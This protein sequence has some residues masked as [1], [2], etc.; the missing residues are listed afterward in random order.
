MLSCK[1]L[2]LPKTLIFHLGPIVEAAEKTTN[3]PQARARGAIYLSVS[4]NLQGG[5]EVMALNTGLLL[6]TS[7]VTKLP[8]T[9]VVVKTVEN[10]PYSQVLRA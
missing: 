5:H 2:N 8:I 10:L 9:D 3:T 6:S 4:D 1:I 7:T